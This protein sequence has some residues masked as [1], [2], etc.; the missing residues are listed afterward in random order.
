VHNRARSDE[1]LA[2]G[3][4]LLLPPS[5]TPD[6]APPDVEDVVVSGPERFRYEGRERVF[7][8]VVAGDDLAEVARAFR[9]DAGDL[10]LWN[11]IDERASLQVGMMLQLFVPEGVELT[12]VRFAREENAGKRLLAGSTTFISHFEGE[13]GRQRLELRAKEG[14]TLASIGRRY[15]LSAGM[16]E[17][18]NH[19]WRGEVLNDGAPVV[20]YAKYGPQLREVFVSRAPDPLPPLAPPHPGAL[21][22]LPARA[23]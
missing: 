11:A 23:E 12:D 7:Y 16:M 19:F 15:G 13:Q 18:I 4:L 5:G 14:E 9:V 8:R 2:P 20:V 10:V 17:R 21:P 6:K 3:S 1:L 22:R